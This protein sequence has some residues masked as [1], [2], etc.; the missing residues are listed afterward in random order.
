MHLFQERFQSVLPWRIAVPAVRTQSLGRGAVPGGQAWT[1]LCGWLT[2]RSR[3][4]KKAG[5][6]KAVAA[7]VVTPTK[8]QH[9]TD[10][11]RQVRVV[12]TA[13]GVQSLAGRQDYDHMY[14]SSTRDYLA[15]VTP[16]RA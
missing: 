7:E 13:M 8:L 6:H 10:S 4:S 3:L 12:K 9:S 5:S 1:W 16:C 2:L 11:T 14:A 15:C